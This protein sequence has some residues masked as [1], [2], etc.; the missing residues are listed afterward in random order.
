MKKYLFL[1]I[2]IICLAIVSCR[3]AIDEVTPVIV[4]DQVIEYVGKLP[5]HNF[6]SRNLVSLAQAKAMEDGIII[7]HRDNQV[8]H[9]RALE[10]DKYCY[11]VA[12]GFVREAIKATE[13]FQQT[14]VGSESNPFSL[15]GIFGVAGLSGFVGKQY[16]KRSGDFT[17][18]EH[19]AE[20]Q[21]AKESV[22]KEMNGGK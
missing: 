7:T 21:K 11:D 8:Q 1:L 9:L 12:S 6:F 3:S 10:D 2:C 14:V 16:F 18:D 4:E 19:E 17:P 13:E 20:V 22:R 5:P 15:L